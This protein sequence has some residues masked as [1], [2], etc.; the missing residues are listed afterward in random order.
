MTMSRVVAVLL[1]MAAISFAQPNN[2]GWYRSPALHGD[3]IAF[4]AEGDLW[5]VGVEGGLA[6]RLTSNPGDESAAV[7][8]TDG[9][10]IAFNADYEGSPEIYTMPATGGL[11]LRRTY[12]GGG[13]RP[14]GWTQDGKLLYSTHHFSSLPDAQLATIDGKNQIQR[15]PLS[16]A[17]QGCYDGR[18]NVLFFTRLERQPSFTK[19]YQGGSAENLWR[20]DPGKEAVPLTA[21]YA[22][23]SRNPMWWDN[24]IYFLTIGTAR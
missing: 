17:A 4:T 22:G 14:A 3:T 20:Y 8:S 6:R 13:A 19:R 2:R 23:T 24:R 7:F 12:E 15:I 9:A 21:D 10:T 16:Q 1:L 11:P 5:L 18:G